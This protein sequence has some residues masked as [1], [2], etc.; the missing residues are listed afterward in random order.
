MNV[1]LRQLRAFVAVAHSGS[2]TDAAASLHITQSALSGL[3]KELESALGVQV[4]QRSTRKVQLSAIGA[5][6]LP[7]AAR[8]LQDL[9]GALQAIVDL[10][11]LKSGVVRVA[12]PQLIACSL[13]PEVMGAFARKFPDIEVRLT[14]CV[15][16]DVAS[17]VQSGEV[18]FAIGPE[19]SAA[20]DIAARLLFDMPFVAVFPADHPLSACK[21]VT[22]TDI[23][24]YPLISLQGEYTQMIRANL[25]GAAHGLTFTPKVEVAFMTTAISMVSA[26]LGVTTCLPYARALIKQY[27][28]QARTLTRPTVRRKFHLLTK[29]DR[30]LSPAAHAFADF[31][32]LYVEQ[33]KWGDMFGRGMKSPG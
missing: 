24:A 16:E 15:V 8:I 7:L 11:S 29:T 27:D 23:L 32:V 4:V 25:Q 3:I 26:G 12:V 17:R 22:W 30:V 28:L 5:E 19:R 6:F 13:M 10:K 2:F 20:S 18:D 9:D 33:E 31:L 14:D 21:R 1:S